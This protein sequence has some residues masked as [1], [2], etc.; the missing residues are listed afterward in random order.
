LLGKKIP[1]L[2]CRD[3]AMHGLK[4]EHRE[5]P[6]GTF[7]IAGQIGAQK[8][9]HHVTQL[10]FVPRT[11]TALP[12]AKPDSFVAVDLFPNGLQLNPNGIVGQRPDELTDG[13]P[14]LVAVAGLVRVAAWEWHRAENR[15][16]VALSAKLLI[17]P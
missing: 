12:N 15:A 2:P 7:R 14:Q 11:S 17:T 3:V 10:A 5:H 8:C 6:Q 1:Q 9:E 4:G 13:P 16:A